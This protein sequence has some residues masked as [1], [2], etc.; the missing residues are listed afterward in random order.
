MNTEPAYQRAVLPASGNL[1]NFVA[2]LFHLLPKNLLSFITGF[3]VRLELPH[4]LQVVANRAF[5]SAFKLN[6]SEA[7]LPLAS[8]KSIEEVF[9]RRLKPGMRPVTG[10]VCSPSD[11]F[12]AR[13]GPAEGGTAIQAKGIYFSLQDLVFGS[14]QDGEGAARPDFVWSQTVYLAPHNYHRV[15]SPFAGELTAIRYLPGQL[16]PVNVPFVLRIPRLFARNERLVFDIALA[17]GGKAYVVMVGAFNVGRMETPFLP[18]FATN[19]AS[20]Q[21]GAQPE[22]HRMQP[23]RTVAA[24]DE[25]G[26]FLLGSTVVIGYDRKALEGIKL[27]EA[28]ENRPILM[29]QSLVREPT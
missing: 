18:D 14:T 7:E 19:A 4:P 6:M 16:W 1:L 12:F 17:N 8:Y 27:V 28:A 25:L 20:R 26:T 23:P 5:A 29:G 2:L 15:H 21:L 11:G 24:G 22:T 3:I 13:S 10:A 9:T